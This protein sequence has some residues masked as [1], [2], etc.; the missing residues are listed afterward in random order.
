[1]K[2]IISKWIGYFER[3]PGL[4]AL[5]LVAIAATGISLIGLTV[6]ASDDVPAPPRTPAPS[7]ELSPTE[8]MRGTLVTVTGAGW[9]AGETVFVRLDESAT[10]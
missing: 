6:I 2:S 9:R 5:A 8:G 10:G 3:R 7:I 4:A 1:M